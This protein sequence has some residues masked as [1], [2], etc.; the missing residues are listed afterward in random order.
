MNKLELNPEIRSRLAS[1]VTPNDAQGLRAACH[2]LVMIIVAVL[3]P[4]FGSAGFVASV[5]ICGIAQRSL[6][7]LVHEASHQILF[8]RR[9]LN[10]ALGLLS[11]AT[12]V[13]SYSAYKRS[14]FDHHRA[15][16][17]EDLDPEV[18]FHDEQY[19]LLGNGNRSLLLLLSGYCTIRYIKYVFTDRGLT[20]GRSFRD[21]V[22]LILFWMACIYLSLQVPLLRA[23]TVAWIVALVYV[24]PIVGWLCEL[25]EHYPYDRDDW[26]ETFQS[27]NRLGSKWEKW[28]LGIHN[29]NYHLIHHLFPGIPYFNL[30]AAH[31]V[32]L[33][34]PEYHAVADES[35]GVLSRSQTGTPSLLFQAMCRTKKVA[36]TRAEHSKEQP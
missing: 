28:I 34:V 30:P 17:V 9:V 35:P 13:Q 33:A 32:L 7:T 19:R 3:L 6:S 18:L 12:V 14:H 31:A 36:S 24:Y 16:G 5:F 23:P 21:Y 10:E 4:M 8:R 29:E 1:L 11:S 2:S 26:N 20:A 25:G 15:L 22:A 27:R